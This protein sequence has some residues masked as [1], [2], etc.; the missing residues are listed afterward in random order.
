MDFWNYELSMR[1]RDPRFRADWSRLGPVLSRAAVE[2]VDAASRDEYQGLNFYS[3]YNKSTD[4]ELHRW[5]TGVVAGFLGVSVSMVPRQ[6]KRS[7]PK[8]PTRHEAIGRCPACGADMRGTEE[9]GLDVRM[10]TDMISL[11]WVDN[12]DIA[13]TH[14]ILRRRYGPIRASRYGRGY[15]PCGLAAVGG[16]DAE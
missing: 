13:G 3:S 11:A 5:A 14:L 1:A 7:P 16:P 4:R 9:K 6:K 8:C 10:A 12:Y 2:V 15:L